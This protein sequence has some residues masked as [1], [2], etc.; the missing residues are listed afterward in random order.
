MD[1]TLKSHGTTFHAGTVEKLVLEGSLSPAHLPGGATAVVLNVTAV[2][3]TAS[4][5]LTVWPYGVARP[6]T[7]NL[8]WSDSHAHANAVTVSLGAGDAID[9][10]N[11]AGNVDLK[12]AIDGYYVA[13]PAG[14]PGP[15]GAPGAKGDQGVK[16]DPGPPGAPGLSNSH[17]YDTWASSSTGFLFHEVS[18]AQLY[19]PAGS[20]FVSTHIVLTEEDTSDQNWSCQLYVN[21]TDTFQDLIDSAQGRM[22]AFDYP[23]TGDETNTSLN[24]AVLFTQ[25]GYVIVSC[26]GYDLYAQARLD[27]VSVNAIN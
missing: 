11:H 16:G 18:V 27:A 21:Y 9:F 3:G 12:V 8:N 15:P 24:G 14:P 25:P 7:S 13:T 2:N 1:T 22:Q 4:S 20:Y 26:T 23:D 6:S 5:Y 19:V 10:Y 17:A